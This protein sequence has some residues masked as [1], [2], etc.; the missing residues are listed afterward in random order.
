M[1]RRPFILIVL[2][3]LL[4]VSA[5]SPAVAAAPRGTSGLPEIIPEPLPTPGGGE[6]SGI[7]LDLFVL[8][9]PVQGQNIMPPRVVDPFVAAPSEQFP[10]PPSPPEGSGPFVGLPVLTR[11]SPDGAIVWQVALPYPGLE[12]TEISADR[13]VTEDAFYLAVLGDVNR[14]N[15]LNRVVKYDGNGQYAWERAIGPAVRSVSANPVFGGAY[16]A[17]DELGVFRLDGGGSVVWGPLDL[18]PSHPGV[19]LHDRE[20]STDLKTGGV[21]V[22]FHQDG[23]ESGLIK[24]APDG[25]KLWQRTIPIASRP[26]ANPLDGGVYVASSEPGFDLAHSARY[27]PDGSLLWM[28]E[29]FPAPANIVR[30]LATREGGLMITGCGELGCLTPEGDVHWCI[31]NDDGAGHVFGTR[32]LAGD[33]G[34]DVFYTAQDQLDHGVSKYDGNTHV[35]LWHLDPTMDPR[36]FTL[37]MGVPAAENHAPDCSAAFVE[38]LPI[39]PPGSGFETVCIHRVTDVDGDDVTIQVRGITQ[40]EPVYGGEHTCPDATLVN[41]VATL[42]PE[43]NAG[44]NGRVYEVTFIATDTK[45]A[46]CESKLQVCVPA[47]GPTL[48]CCTNDGQLYNSLTGCNGNSARTAEPL[49]IASPVR[50]G[51]GVQ[52]EYVLE[53]AGNV[54]IAVFDVSGRR[55]ATLLDE[56]RNAGTHTLGWSAAGLRGGVYFCRVRA[57]ALVLTRSLV[58]AP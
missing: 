10:E 41:G 32:G 34:A 3:S 20:V 5:F 4:A 22:T 13:N 49:R 21:Y 14:V 48:D 42:R 17:D 56:Y 28:K 58:I 9:L 39:W 37:Y 19:A 12:N 44:G 23:G 15:G 11:V 8:G 36:I 45:G 2:A 40:D 47:S 31:C 6:I 46:S 57:G 53:T 25:E 24:V 29:H 55:V 16:V 18:G 26:I 52:L 33:P 7:R 43:A 27:G 51:T 50:T 38:L 35:A 54:E 1:T 30:G